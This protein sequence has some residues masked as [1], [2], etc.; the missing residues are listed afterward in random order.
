MLFVDQNFVFLQGYLIPAKK[1]T[2]LANFFVDGVICYKNENDPYPLTWAT[3]TGNS[4]ATSAI[5]VKM[6]NAF[7]TYFTTSGREKMYGYNRRGKCDIRLMRDKTLSLS[8]LDNLSLYLRKKLRD[9]ISG[10]GLSHVEISGKQGYVTIANH[11]KFSAT[12]L[13][14]RLGLDYSD[15][16]GA[17]IM[18]LMSNSEKKLFKYDANFPP[19]SHDKRKREAEKES[20]SIPP[21]KM[22][23]S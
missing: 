3:G 20:E 23:R 7:C 17:P 16:Q 13:A 18:E 8:D 21:A 19:L 1:P 12:E 14:V 9:Y 15:W 5:R 11:R 4:G 2:E 22:P 6:S 10:K